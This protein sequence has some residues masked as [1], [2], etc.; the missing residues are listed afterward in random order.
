VTAHRTATLVKVLVGV[1]LAACSATF[2]GTVVAVWQ[3][4]HRW[5]P[6][7]GYSEQVVVGSHRIAMTPDAA[8]TIA[9]TKCNRTSRPVQVR[10]RMYWVSE[11]PGGA[12]LLVFSGIA[13][14]KPGC[15]TQTFVNAVPDVVRSRFAATVDRFPVQRWYLTGVEIPVDSKGQDGVQVHWRSESFDLVAQEE[16]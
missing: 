9:G 15:T 4:T 13:S 10:G 7:T 6:L 12:T 5:V 1:A 2:G 16:G 8:V 3:S 14:R 11:K